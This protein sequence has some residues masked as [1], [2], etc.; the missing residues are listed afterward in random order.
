M[1]SPM[2]HKGNPKQLTK[3]SHMHQKGGSSARP[4][5]SS[6]DWLVAEDDLLSQFFRDFSAWP[7]TLSAT[8]ALGLLRV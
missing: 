4:V 2:H 5:I 6:N 3:T 7:R 1:Q 8:V